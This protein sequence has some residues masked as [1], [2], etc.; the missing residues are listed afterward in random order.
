[1]NPGIPRS[2]LA[3]SKMN[4]PTYPPFAPRETYGGIPYPKFARIYKRW[5]NSPKNF[6]KEHSP[7]I[8]K[9]FGEYRNELDRWE[10]ETRSQR[11]EEK[12][13]LREARILPTAPDGMEKIIEFRPS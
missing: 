5:E 2:R 4:L 9:A 13:I 3:L 12:R 10:L 11:L 6:M 8:F 7:K 1:M